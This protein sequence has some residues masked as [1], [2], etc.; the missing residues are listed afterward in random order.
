MKEWVKNWIRSK[1]PRK[2]R[3]YVYNAPLHI[4]QKLVKVHLSPELRKK[5][6]KRNVGIRREDK[7]KILRGQFKGKTGKV[8]RVEVKVPKIFVTGIEFLKKDGS[9]A[10]YPIN[11]SNIIIEELHMDD[12]RR[13]KKTESKKEEA[14]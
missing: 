1:K 5:Y 11:P 4:Q 7:V 12:K 2:Q 8:E 3:K 6:G 14:K 13:I 9:K 10:L